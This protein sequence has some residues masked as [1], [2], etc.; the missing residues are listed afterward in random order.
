MFNH[1]DF[2]QILYHILSYG[3]CEGDHSGGNRHCKHSLNIANCIQL[4][5]KTLST[6]RNVV[7]GFC[8]YFCD[9]TK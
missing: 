6:V 4:L 8:G 5:N 1:S 3:W 9:N 2:Y 7:L